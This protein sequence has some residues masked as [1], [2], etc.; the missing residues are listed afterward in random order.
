MVFKFKITY[1]L[2][3]TVS[4]WNPEYKRFIRMNT[5]GNIDSVIQTNGILPQY[6][7][8]EK[9]E[10]VKLKLTE[11][12][13]L[14]GLVANCCVK[15]IYITKGTLYAISNDNSIYQYELNST[16]TSNMSWKVISKP[17]F[18]PRMFTV[19]KSKKGDHA[20]IC[21]LS[22]NY[23]MCYSFITPSKTTIDEW[24]TT[25]SIR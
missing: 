24:Y 10:I 13:K 23:T 8:L 20:M 19:I 6:N 2:D 17:T 16:S 18:I 12:P 21:C 7:T 3:G 5:D 22:T 4:L 11:T 14:W 1:Y 15:Y 25:S 9:W